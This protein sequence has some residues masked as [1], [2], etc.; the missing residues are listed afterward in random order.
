MLYNGLFRH[1]LVCCAAALFV[2]P[3]QQFFMNNIYNMPISFPKADWIFLCICGIWGSTR[4]I[5]CETSF[6]P[7]EQ[8]S[9]DYDNISWT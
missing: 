8:E 1:V 5:I 7:V 6:S 4:K 3:Q 9:S 2:I